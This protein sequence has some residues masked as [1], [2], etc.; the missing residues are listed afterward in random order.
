MFSHSTYAIFKGH[1]LSLQVF[2]TFF[3]S[4][5]NRKSSYK[6]QHFNFTDLYV[7]FPGLF[8]KKTR[9]SRQDPLPESLGQNAQETHSQLPSR[10]WLDRECRSLSTL[11]LHNLSVICYV[12][13]LLDLSKAPVRFQLTITDHALDWG[14]DAQYHW[15]LVIISYQNGAATKLPLYSS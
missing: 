3:I 11:K 14:H 13:E 4:P 9:S 12:Y 15:I 10:Q 8:A 5:M 2:Q 7:H 6:L 1:N